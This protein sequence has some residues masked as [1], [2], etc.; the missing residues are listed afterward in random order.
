VALK[1]TLI[2][3]DT[4]EIEAALRQCDVTLRPAPMAEL[5]G[6]AQASE[7]QPDIVV[8]DLRGHE[9]VPPALTALK[10]QH[11][12]TGVVIVARTLA[13]DLV[14]AAL[15]AGANECVVEPLSR[16]DLEA[17]MTRVVTM[18]EPRAASQVFAMIGVKGG[19]GATSVAV[20][21]ATTLARIA[22]SGALLVDLNLAR[23]DAALYLGL[24]PRFSVV[25]ALENVHKLDEAYFR[26][27]V[28]RTPSRLDLLAAPE[29]GSALRVDA[30]RVRGLIDFASKHFEFTVLDVPR[31]EPAALDALEAATAIVLVTTQELPAVRSA[32]LMAARLRQR[33]GQARVKVVM[34]RLDRQAE[35]AHEDVEKVLGIP[36][37]H[38]LPSEYRLT[39]ESLNRG[40]PLVLENHSALAES[41][42]TFARSLAGLRTAKKHDEKGGQKGGGWLS[43]LAGRGSRAAQG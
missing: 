34:S 2:G 29:A 37:A 6:L 24:E 9:G 32:A 26:G 18:R 15:R 28:V 11:P 23:G 35:I 27:L 22:T 31:T 42:D 1:V 30:G 43:R 3:H 8:L 16:E 25:D 38:V 19:V 39:M 7:P 5:T 20:N 14:L 10:R 40:R 12:G 17:A 4:Q 41:L 33:Y 21:V 13:P 36:V